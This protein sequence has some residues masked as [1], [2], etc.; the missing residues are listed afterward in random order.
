MSQAKVPPLPSHYVSRPEVIREL[1]QSLFSPS[2]TGVLVVSAIYGL[3]G[4]GKSTVAAALAR[5]PEV[6]SHFPD[7]VLWAT[8]GQQPD[9]LSFLNSWIRAL[10]DYDYKPTTKEAAGEH[11]RTLLAEKAALLVVDDVWDAEHFEFFRVGSAACRVLATTRSAPIQGASSFVVPPSHE[12]VDD[13]Q[14][15]RLPHHC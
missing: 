1:K 7:G 15:E 9:L 8:L 5:D 4:I 2:Q 6:L 14:T 11:L 3:G 13:K 12:Y 10:G